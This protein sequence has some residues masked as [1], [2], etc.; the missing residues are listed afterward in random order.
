MEKKLFT[1]EE[2]NTEK[3]GGMRKIEPVWACRREMVIWVVGC[4]ISQIDLVL[5]TFHLTRSGGR[6]GSRRRR[7]K[8]KN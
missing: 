8:K 2:I 1:S 5:S 4:E 6:R 7:E 3:E